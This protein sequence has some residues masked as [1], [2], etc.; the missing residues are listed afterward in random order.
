MKHSCQVLCRTQD[1]HPKLSLTVLHLQSVTLEQL[2]KAPFQPIE[3]AVRHIVLIP[4]VLE[5]KLQ[6]WTVAIELHRAV[7]QRQQEEWTTV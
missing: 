4:L 1:S 7:L 6:V 5:G 3:I 2:L